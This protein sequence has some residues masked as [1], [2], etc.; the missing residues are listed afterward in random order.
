MA[1]APPLTAI[2]HGSPGAYRKD[3]PGLDV[4]GPTEAMEP[5]LIPVI[6][7]PFPAGQRRQGHRF[8]PGEV[9]KDIDGGRHVYSDP[10]I[11]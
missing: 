5:D 3:D 9:H 7:Q 11:R 10:A 6:F 8:C 2:F 1:H 4:A